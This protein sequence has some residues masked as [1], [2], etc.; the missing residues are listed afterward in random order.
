MDEMG[1]DDRLQSG[2]WNEAVEQRACALA[3]KVHRVVPV[4]PDNRPRDRSLI[5]KACALVALG[6][7]PECWLIDG[8]ESVKQGKRKRRPQGYLFR[9]LDAGAADRKLNLRQL[10]AR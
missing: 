8:V 3:R 9:V 5:L 6:V 1:R 4:H 2:S 7:L 10:L